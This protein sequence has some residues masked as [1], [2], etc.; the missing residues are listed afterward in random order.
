MGAETHF[1][2]KLAF[3]ALKTPPARRGRGLALDWARPTSGRRNSD[4]AI[5]RQG[6]QALSELTPHSGSG[7]HPAETPLLTDGLAGGFD[8]E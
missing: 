4:S 6:G 3:H 1:F 7:K 2:F 5:D 8:G